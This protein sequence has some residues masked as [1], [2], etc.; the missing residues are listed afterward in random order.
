MTM[1]NDGSCTAT[2]TIGVLCLAAMCLFAPPL[3]AQTKPETGITPQWSTRAP[4]IEGNSEMAVAHLDGRIYV[5]GGYPSTRVSV[6]T[7]QV[8]DIETDSWRLTTS[9]PTT[10]N[11]ASAVGLDGVVYVIGGQLSAGGRGAAA[12]YTSAV[13]AF[14]PKTEKWTVRVD[15]DGPQR[16]G[17]CRH[18][19]Q[20][21][22]RRRASAARARFRRLRSQGRQMDVPARYA[23]GTKSYRGSGNGR[24]ALC[25]RRTLRRWLQKRN[26]RGAGGL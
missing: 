18:R 16:H 24:Q 19:R 20:D 13:H 12:G 7:V 2:K 6:D 8:Y 11:H 1:A 15:A 9:Y 26:H 17:G 14:D 23:D 5:V 10:I 4:L 25:C 22:C 21:L 3:A